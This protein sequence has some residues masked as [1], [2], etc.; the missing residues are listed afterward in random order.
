MELRGQLALTRRPVYR[1]CPEDPA[2]P[3]GGGGGV[4]RVTLGVGN[5]GEHFTNTSKT[6]GQPQ[7]TWRRRQD[8]IVINHEVAGSIH[9]VRTLTILQ[10]AGFEEQHLRFLFYFVERVFPQIFHI[11]SYYTTHRVG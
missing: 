10:G 5:I 3:G 8:I 1:V 6:P 2:G 4:S 9:T 11:Y 7:G